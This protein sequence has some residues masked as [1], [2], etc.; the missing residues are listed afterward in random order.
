MIQGSPVDQARSQLF[1]I[2][3]QT[4][5]LAQTS[6][7]SA[8]SG[9]TGLQ[10]EEDG[11]VT[12]SPGS[13]IDKKFVVHAVIGSG[14]MGAVYRVHHQMLNKDLAL[15]TFR[16]S[17]HIQSAW[18]SFQNEAKILAALKN[19]HVIEVYD[20]GFAENKL[21]YY[22]MELLDGESLDQLLK[23]QGP[24]DL[25]LAIELFRQACLGL[26]AA[27][28]R[29]ILHSDVKPANLFVVENRQRDRISYTL[30]VLDFGI[31][32]MI[33]DETQ[34]ETGERMLFGSPLYMSP[35]Q[36]QGEKLAETS[37]VYSL[38]CALFE[39]LT[40]RPPFYGES[41]LATLHMHITVPA[42]L[43]SKYFQDGS[44]PNRLVGLV[45]RM[46]E[47]DPAK[48]IASM[49]AVEEELALIAAKM[50]SPADIRKRGLP[51]FSREND[52][53]DSDASS[54]VDD[55]HSMSAN[56]NGAAIYMKAALIAVS[57]VLV[58]GA[59]AALTV[60][61][62]HPPP[63][64]KEP[65]VAHEPLASSTLLKRSALT[66]PA[67]DYS[68]KEPEPYCARPIDHLVR[69]FQFPAQAIG[70]L[71]ISYGNRNGVQAQGKVEFP[72]RNVKKLAFRGDHNVFHYPIFLAG[73]QGDDLSRVAVEVKT[74][75]PAAERVARAN[76]IIHY[77]RHVTAVE[78]LS[79]KGFSP[80]QRCLSDLEKLP[81]VTNL[82]FTAPEDETLF[83][84]GSWLK[85]YSRLRNLHSLELA[86]KTNLRP[87][88]Q[89][90]KKN[91]ML[92][93]LTLNNCDLAEGDI[94]CINKI[95][96]LYNLC[97]NANP[98]VTDAALSH[99]KNNQTIT[100]LTLLDCGIT[101]KSLETL[102]T[103]PKLEYLIV[104]QSV[105]QDRV[106]QLLAANKRRY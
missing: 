8:V 61:N 29:G 13:V 20:F 93:Q 101:V 5:T 12:W 89:A 90:L 75:E 85:D 56:S 49:S 19:R 15:K 39:C 69:R 34:R 68:A 28:Q 105:P 94:D 31:A 66:L 17:N 21:P 45:A 100:K 76:A 82:T 46:L 16:V 7:I 81:E 42:P 55:D 79:L 78:N 54:D 6:T 95:P 41:A 87:I 32:R 11:T 83:E 44:V 14:G 18:Q 70:V 50:Q 80:D 43:L 73:F 48:R 98:K 65:P 67:I 63:P 35:E 23:R 25:P 99:L 103:L 64:P 92:N 53:A 96:Q 26:A 30:K 97:I 60:L 57:C 33:S 71:E 91:N 3:G 88:L 51:N 58:A 77:L 9:L 72:E 62:F 74:E 47:K 24:L 52:D 10:L 106:T 2:Q 59:V 27:H 1:T 104:P 4:V 86:N 38:G 37:D 36:C 22:A 84:D 40:G 102:K